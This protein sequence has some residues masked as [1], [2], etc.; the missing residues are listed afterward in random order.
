MFDQI[1]QLV[2][3]QLNAH[4]QIAGNIPAEQAD[5]IHHEIA[6]HISNGLQ[7][8]QPVQPES[9]GILSQLEN[10]LASGGLATSAITGG[11]VGTLAGKF[12]LPP[13]I[14]GAIAAALPGLIK[15]YE[16]RNNT[17]LVNA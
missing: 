6:T 14:T 13:M 4:P 3:E 7:N 8:P 5:E 9:G 1:L 16:N 10:S 17:P 2:K 12:G 15:K 11:L